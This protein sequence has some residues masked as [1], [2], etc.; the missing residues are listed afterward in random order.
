M[1]QRRTE[2]RKAAKQ[3]RHID[4]ERTRFPSQIRREIFHGLRPDAARPMSGGA[5][6]LRGG[7]FEDTGDEFRLERRA[8]RL[9]GLVARQAVDAFFAQCRQRMT[10]ARRTMSPDA[11]SRDAS[12]VGV[13]YFSLAGRRTS[14]VRVRRSCRSLRTIKT[15]ARLGRLIPLIPYCE[16][17]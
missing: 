16:R 12:F 6:R 13:R 2:L 7:Q 4:D 11:H 17:R 1:A 9:T 15:R 10:L 5:G 3:A 14:G 8:A